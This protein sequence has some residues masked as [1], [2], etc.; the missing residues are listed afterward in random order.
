MARVASRRESDSAVN[1]VVLGGLISLA[2]SVATTL[3]V[4][5][6]AFKH[7]LDYRWDKDR[8]D[9]VT[10]SRLATR[11]ARG[12]IHA[13]SRGELVA[14]P[15][16]S[17]PEA[18]DDLMDEAYYELEKLALLFPEHQSDVAHIQ[19]SLVDLATLTR[20]TTPGDEGYA[21]QAQTFKNDID[22]RLDAIR[23][24]AQGR[25]K[26]ATMRGKSMQ[27]GRSTA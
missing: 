18:V 25:L 3:V 21:A 4:S 15:P 19:Q 16:R 13:W 1:D 10:T 20:S 23:K 27:S 5:F 8:L 11:R 6:I 7:E 12:K 26:I 9:I 22:V 24:A 2:S 14:V 17:R